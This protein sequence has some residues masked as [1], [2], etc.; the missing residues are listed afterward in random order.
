VLALLSSVKVNADVQKRPKRTR[1]HK[2]GTGQATGTTGATTRNKTVVLD[3]GKEEDMMFQ[4]NT[5]AVLDKDNDTMLPHNNA[6]IL[7][8]IGSCYK[9]LLT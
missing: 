6:N 3:D 5:M 8:T 7:V 2:G 1:T 9:Q 4:Q